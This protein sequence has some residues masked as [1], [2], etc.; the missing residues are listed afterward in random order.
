MELSW[1]TKTK[2]GFVLAI[3][4]LLLGLIAW[5]LVA[6]TDPLAPITLAGV[7]ILGWLILPCLAFLAGFLGYFA[8][9]PYGREV[10]IL[11]VPAGLGILSMRGGIM[12]ILMQS[13]ATVAGRQAVYAN[14]RWEPIAWLALVAL[15]YAGVCFG[16]RCRKSTPTAI[17]EI[18]HET[19]H[20]AYPHGLLA[21]MLS[22]IVALILIGAF[23]Q[24]T[25]AGILPF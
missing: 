9:W 17:P 16:A 19:K 3:G 6:P 22:T 23:V 13:N 14:L 18:H 11:A 1:I 5:P 2:I 4:G 24:N 20:R 15:G 25:G 10:G 21:V 12:R 7:Q 8:G